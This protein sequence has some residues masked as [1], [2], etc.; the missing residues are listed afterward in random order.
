MTVSTINITSGPYTGNGIAD[1]F[2]YTFKVNTENDLVVYET[3][4]VGVRITLV[5]DTDYIV[6]SVGTDGGGTIVRNAGPLPTGYEWFIRANYKETQLTSF[7]SQGAFFPDLHENA[8]D[9]LTILIQ[10]LEDGRDRSPTLP[11]TYTGYLPIILEEPVAGYALRWSGDEKSIESYDPSTVSN[12]EIANDKVVINY[13][14]LNLAL[15]DSS[16]KLNQSCS[17]QERVA[18]EGGGSMWDV[19]PASLP[20]ENGVNAL[21]SIVDPSL[22]LV[23]RSPYTSASLGRTLNPVITDLRSVLAKDGDT[24]SIVI[25]GVSYAYVFDVASTQFDNGVTCLQAGTAPGRWQ[26]TSTLAYSPFTLSVGDDF[27]TVNAAVAH[28][29]QYAPKPGDT[30]EVVLQTGFVMAEQIITRSVDLS[31]I[32]L[33]AIDPVVTVTRSSMT[34]VLGTQFPLFG[35]ERGGRTPTI[36]CN[37]T[38]DGTGD[39]TGRDFVYCVNGGGSVVLPGAGC[40]GA[41]DGL[42]AEGA[43]SYI[44]ASGAVVQDSLNINLVAKFGA[45]I[46]GSNGNF[47][48]ALLDNIYAEGAATINAQGVIAID[49]AQY[50]VRAIAGSSVVVTGSFLTGAG[51]NG[52]LASDGSTVEAANSSVA[53]SNRGYVARDGSTITAKEGDASSCSSSAVYCVGSIVYIVDG[54]LSGAGDYAVQAFDGSTVVAS[55]S[56]LSGAS[57]GGGGVDAT[58]GSRVMVHNSDCQRGGSPSSSDIAVSFGSTVVARDAIGGTNVSINTLHPEGIIY[59]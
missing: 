59:R 55:Y 35:A 31:W 29:S 12:E 4:D 36:S 52:I 56:N 10:Q 42:F 17:L 14:T 43:G 20:A 30:C 28:A 5:V 26:Q 54:D 47:S 39:A 25:D 48:G 22:M 38:I 51:T 15:N 24:A 21:I 13:A 23:H 18:G 27:A 45:S 37:F 53:G 32:T 11:D 50:N 6:N 3:D 57:G 7:T 40:I 33:T 46:K 2:S 16:L 1:T 9:K 41:W 49:A 44:D 8:M 19:V 58:L 34:S